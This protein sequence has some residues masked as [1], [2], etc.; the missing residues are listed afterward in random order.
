[1]YRPDFRQYKHSQI[2]VHSAKGSTWEDHKYVKRV[3][4]TYYYPNDYEG[5]RH[6]SDLGEKDKSNS[7]DETKE[8]EEDKKKRDT[9][10]INEI[11]DFTGMKEESIQKLMEIA[12]T[13]G[14]DSPEYK[15]LCDDLSEGFKDQYDKITN[16]LKKN[17]SGGAKYSEADYDALAKEVVRG[18]F[19]NGQQ[20]KDLLGENYAEVQKRVN[21]IMKKSGSTKVSE[22]KGSDTA[23][24]GEAAISKASSLSVSKSTSSAKAPDS[25]QYM[26][27]Y[28][29]QRQRN[30]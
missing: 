4:G 20:R 11:S 13:K 8:S 19:G 26:S 7:K 23:K 14:Y 30:K 9:D 28:E 10:T 5:G 29:R 21:E 24:A 2:L 25:S 16:T 15:E 3:D 27:V 17:D 1:M 6:I 18:N 22:A 12:R